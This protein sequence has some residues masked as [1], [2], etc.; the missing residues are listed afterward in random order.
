MKQ[1]IK[2]IIESIKNSKY[3]HQAFVHTS[4]QKENENEQSYERLEFLGDSVLSF[5][6]SLYL[7]FNFPNYS[8]GQMSKLKQLMV[9]KETLID[10]SKETGISKFLKLGS[11]EK[12]NK[13]EKERILGDIFESFLAALY[14][15]KG[16]KGVSKFLNL[17]LF[18]WVKGKE[19]II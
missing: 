15:E 7:F 19:N 9:R 6:T 12:N 18:N 1:Q 11:S 10:L 16:E 14:L 3:F 5:A 4:F 8:E 17:T 13:K 2:K